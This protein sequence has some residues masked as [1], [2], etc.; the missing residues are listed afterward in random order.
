MACIFVTC[1]ILSQIFDATRDVLSFGLGAVP[2]AVEGAIM[3][4]SDMR[5][6][7]GRAIEDRL[8][9][10]WA[11]V[12]K[13]HAADD[14][15]WVRL[16]SRSNPKDCSDICESPGHHCVGFAFRRRSGLFDALLR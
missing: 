16:I 1:L 8:S 4:E 13:R 15:G 3:M 9:T 7:V 14:L 2:I 5:Y 12:Q 6:P 11:A 10:R